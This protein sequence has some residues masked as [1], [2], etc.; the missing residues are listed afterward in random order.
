MPFLATTTTVAFVVLGAARDRAVSVKDERAA[1]GHG[2]TSWVY[3]A[4]SASAVSAVI[5]ELRCEFGQPAD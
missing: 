1:A 3:L 2:A 4:V 5:A